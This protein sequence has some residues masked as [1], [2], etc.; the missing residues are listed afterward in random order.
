MNSDHDAKFKALFSNRYLMEQL[1]GGF[2][3][4][5]L[6]HRLD[7]QSLE[8]F[9]TE[10]VSQDKQGRKYKIRHNDVMWRVRFTDGSEM[11]MLLMV[12]IQSSVDQSMAIRI[13]EYVINWYRYLFHGESTNQLPPIFPIV[14]YDGDRP[15]TA[16]M[17]L[18]DMVTMPD[19]MKRIMTWIEASYYVIDLRRLYED[20]QLPSGNVFAPLLKSLYTAEPSEFN[21]SYEQTRLMLENAKASQEMID[22]VK[23]F[24][25]VSGFIFGIFSHPRVRPGTVRAE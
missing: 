17:K 19:W 2:V 22:H 15:W 21:E 18:S 25:Q 5:H 20:G 7:I 14:I 3:D 24:T 13:A 4:G 12:E 11:Y 8:R 6:T 23:L 9:P 1:I 16:K 10:S